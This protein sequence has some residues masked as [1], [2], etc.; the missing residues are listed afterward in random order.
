MGKN[1]LKKFAEMKT[2]GCVVECPRTEL[3]SDSFR[4]KGAWR[5]DFFHS[6]SVVLEL[7]CGKGEYTVGLALRHPDR[8]YIGIDIKGARIHNGASRVERERIANAGFLRTEIELLDRFFAPGEVSEIWITFPDPQMK[9]VNKRLTSTRFCEMYRRV[10]GSDGIVN[11][12]TD[13]PFL[14]EYTRRMAALNGMEILRDTDDLYG[15]GGAD[16]ET[17][18]KTHYECQWLSRG[19]KIKLLVFRLNGSVSPLREPDVA[20]LEKDDYRALPRFNPAE[21]LAEGTLQL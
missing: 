10:M 15:S 14:Y 8:N 6:S 11:L 20:D 17:S 5:S 13:S 9:K 1:K 21:A 18:I 7:G 3:E 16:E 12:K 19:K 4:Y 2:F